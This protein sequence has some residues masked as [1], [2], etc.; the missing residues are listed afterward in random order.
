MIDKIQTNSLSNIDKI[1]NPT[2]GYRCIV[3]VPIKHH[4]ASSCVTPLPSSH[5]NIVT[6]LFLLEKLSQDITERTKTILT[7]KE[8]HGPC[9]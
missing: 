6:L 2:Y 8:S 5:Y 4:Y 7:L 3:I 1:N 9:S